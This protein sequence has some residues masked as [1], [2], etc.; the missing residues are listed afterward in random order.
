M[1]PSIV[2]I[3]A[4]TNGKNN[5]YRAEVRLQQGREEVIQDMGESNSSPPFF[6]LVR[7]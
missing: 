6:L 5:K 2:S 1:P 7:L 3:V 4:T